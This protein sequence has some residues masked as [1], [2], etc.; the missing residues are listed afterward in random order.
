MVD[1][2]NL[3]AKCNMNKHNER[4]QRDK[5]TIDEIE[6]AIKMIKNLNANGY[7]RITAEKLKV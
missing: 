4:V 7:G 3:E 1:I 5:I 6:K 2:E